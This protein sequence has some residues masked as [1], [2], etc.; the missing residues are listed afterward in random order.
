MPTAR[1]KLNSAHL[2]G[3]LV[4][5]GVLGFITRSPTVFVLA[6]GTL[7]GLSI[8]SGEIRFKGRP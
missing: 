6:A 4:V 5:A 8:H 1:H 7:I 3:A 2:V